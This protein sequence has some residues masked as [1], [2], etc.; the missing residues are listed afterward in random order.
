MA[1]GSNVTQA[2]SELRLT[3]ALRGATADQPREI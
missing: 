2:V 1:P 3:A